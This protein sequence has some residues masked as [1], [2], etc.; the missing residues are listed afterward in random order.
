MDAISSTS[1]RLVIWSDVLV[2][3]QT[4]DTW[5]RASC[6]PRRTQW[7]QPC[8]GAPGNWRQVPLASGTA[9]L[10][11]DGDSVG[12][13]VHDESRLFVATATAAIASTPS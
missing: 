12:T 13:Y 4:A 9:H 10:I 2:P 5:A 7:T 6:Q 11:V 1:A 3:G 8:E